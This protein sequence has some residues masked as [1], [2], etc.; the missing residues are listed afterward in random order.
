MERAAEIEGTLER[1]VFQNSENSW[2][3]AR[4]RNEG[5]DRLIS[6]VGR[7][8]GVSVGESL[9]LKGKWVFNPKFGEQFEIDSFEVRPPAT[10]GGIERYL[11]SGLVRGIGPE[12][13]KRI[14]ERFGTEALAVIDADPERL[15]EVDGIGSKRLAMIREGWGEQQSVREALVFLHQLPIGPALA[16]RIYETYKEETVLRVR[17]DPYALADDVWGIGFQTA[18]R[19]AEALGVDKN[20][21]RRAEAGVLYSLGQLSQAGHVCYPREELARAAARFLDQEEEV[22]DAAIVRLLDAGSVVREEIDEG[23]DLIYRLEMLDAEDGVAK[24]VRALLSDPPAGPR[25]DSH[26][27]LSWLDSA[28][29]FPLGEEQKV[30]VEAAVEERVVVV[31]GG[32]GTGKTTL[33]RSL[34]AILERAGEEVSLAAPTGRAAKKLEEATARPASTIHRLLEFDPRTA[35]FGRNEENPLTS[36]TAIIDE[37]SMVDILLMRHLLAALGPGSR[38]V[39]VGDVDQLPSV[40]PGNVLRDLI[41]SGRVRTVR[42]TEIYRQAR[43]SRIVVNAHRVNEGRMPLL[44]AEASDFRFIEIETGEE[45]LAWIKRFLSEEILPRY[46]LD[47]V[48]DV[49]V[50]APMHRGISGVTNLNRELQALLNPRGEEIRRD[51]RILRMGDKVIQLRN[52]Y[53]LEVFNGDVGRIMDI[54][55]SAEELEVFFG[56]R[57]VRYPFG[58]LDELTLAYAVSV[59]KS[60]GSEYRAV[61]APLLGE[62]FPM[63][64][65]NLLYTAITRGREL[66][67][68]IG[69]KRTIGAAV[70]NNRIR[71]R[72]S[73][74]AHRLRGSAGRREP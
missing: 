26:A 2:T 73:F 27:A 19:I 59:H 63:L 6:I 15:L 31:T 9:R 57:R 38:L 8:P 11:A 71:H 37:V 29:D 22:A 60:Q 40:G 58:H 14:V 4:L 68:L 1:I 51:D 7:L 48:R 25:I 41:D 17:S 32:P 67:V 62:H 12:M 35:L 23:P 61:V 30:A 66:V 43:E 39:L 53:G 49:Q 45:S 34:L 44:E 52:N 54:D 24:A 13:A 46:G 56:G 36:T 47:P 50:I 72:Y 74:L 55:P 33:V 18:D 69:S 10:A 42:L 20:S 28:F 21:P 64:Q 70:R 3:V 5:E 65:R 16:G